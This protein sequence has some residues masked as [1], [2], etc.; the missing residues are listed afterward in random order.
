MPDTRPGRR[1]GGRADARCLS[2]VLLYVTEEFFL[3]RLFWYLRLDTE[4][5]EEVPYLY[6]PL[7]TIYVPYTFPLPPPL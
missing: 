7:S 3:K 1:E 4:E 5:G 2:L 6:Y